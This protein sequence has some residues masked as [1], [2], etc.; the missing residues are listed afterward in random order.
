MTRKIN[1]LIACGSGVA[2][3][4]LASQAVTEICKTY[5]VN[6][7]IETCSMKT[8]EDSSQ[9][10]D[11]V[12]STNRY[13]KDLGKPYMSVTPLITGIGTDKLKE[14]LGNLLKDVANKT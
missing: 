14:Q 8:I 9:N 10:A 1:I 5:E 4:T 13:E 2:T 7:T 6:A 12:L 11:V 3:S